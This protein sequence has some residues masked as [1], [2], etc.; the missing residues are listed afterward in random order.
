MVYMQQLSI[1]YYSWYTLRSYLIRNF[2]NVE[3]DLNALSFSCVTPYR[4]T[5]IYT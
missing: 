3:L 4:N 1:K 5:I 2:Q